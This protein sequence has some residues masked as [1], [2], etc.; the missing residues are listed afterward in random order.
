MATRY[1]NKDFVFLNSLDIPRALGLVHFYVTTTTT[2]LNTY[3]D[4]ALTTPNTNPIVLNAAGR[5][6]VD[7][8]LT[9]VDYKVVITNFDGTDSITIDPVHGAL[10]GTLITNLGTA[11]VTATNGSAARTLSAHFGDRLNLKDFGGTA[12]GV[13]DNASVIDAA[14]AALSSGG[15][16]YIPAGNYLDSGTHTMPAKVSVEGDGIGIS[17]ITGSATSGA[18]FNWTAP[19]ETTIQYCGAV[20]RKCS[21]VGAGTGNTTAAFKIKNKTNITFQDCE[22]DNYKY[23]IQGVRDAAGN[24]VTGFSAKGVRFGRCKTAV[25]APLSWNGML[26]DRACTFSQFEDWGAIIYDT[27]GAQIEG[28]FNSNPTTTGAGHIFMGG[29]SGFH[30]GSYFEG[31]TNADHFLNL[32]SAKDVAGSATNGGIAI[33]T[34]RGGIVA[35]ARWSSAGGVAYGMK[36]DGVQSVLTAGCRASSGI[37]T[38]LARLTSATRGNT[39]IACYPASGTVASFQTAADA[40]FN[41]VEDFATGQVLMRALNC[42][43]S[44]LPDVTAPGQIVYVANETGGGTLALS[45]G[46]TWR[47]VQDLAV[48]S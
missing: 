25:Y 46:V 15:T 18:Q 19:D 3:S 29:C 41:V 16:L 6:A 11:T 7:V 22:I 40:G 8:F 20:I 48:V 21:F 35:G 37:S 1:G 45:N 36:L 47:R 10:D 34:S 42:T 44:T 4:N 2:P 38:A 39:F 23:L 24:A 26:I 32:T 5:F 30:V 33:G 14:L 28:T 12:G 31:N 13:V 27:D 43:V 9:A 17:T